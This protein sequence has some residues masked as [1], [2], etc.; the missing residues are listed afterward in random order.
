VAAAMVTESFAI[1]T[2]GGE[3]IDLPGFAQKASASTVLGAFAFVVHLLP[4][5]LFRR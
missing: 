2:L 3:S 4:P 1:V 5:L